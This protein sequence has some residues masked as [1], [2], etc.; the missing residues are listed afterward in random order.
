MEGVG[1]SSIEAMSDAAG[2]G[3]VEAEA[4]MD[5]SVLAKLIAAIV[6]AVAFVV[7]AVQNSASIEV[8]FLAWDFTT[9]QILVMVLSAVFGIVLWELAGFLRRRAKR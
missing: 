4:G 3:P 2:P 9:Y 6:L 7:F 5:K 1:T 8:E